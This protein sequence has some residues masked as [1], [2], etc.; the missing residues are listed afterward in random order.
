MQRD[1]D[2]LVETTTSKQGLIQQLGRVR[3]NDEEHF[4][5][6]TDTIDLSIASSSSRL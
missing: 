2:H 1:V 6:K 5:L 4:L 3:G